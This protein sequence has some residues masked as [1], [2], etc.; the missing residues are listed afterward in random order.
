MS[1]EQFEHGRGP[2]GAY[3]VGSPQEMIDRI[4]FHHELF[5]HDR[6]LAHMSLGTVPHDAAMHAIELFAT[7]VAPVVREEIAA[8]ESATAASAT[9]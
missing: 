4:L 1:R 6:Y 9:A 8:R 5:G 7:E 3:A 2:R